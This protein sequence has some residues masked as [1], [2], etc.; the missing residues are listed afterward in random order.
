MYN[1]YLHIYTYNTD[2]HFINVTHLIHNIPTVPN[3]LTLYY[4]PITYPLETYLNKDINYIKLQC[5]DSPMKA[6]AFYCK[7]RYKSHI[8][9]V[10]PTYVPIHI[11]QHKIKMN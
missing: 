3:V 5:N 11:M 6:P 10:V 9:Y 2:V 1:E 8:T 7:S 4:F